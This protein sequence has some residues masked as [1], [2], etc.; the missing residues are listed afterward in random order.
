MI[1]E[2]FISLMMILLRITMK[3]A[4]IWKMNTEEWKKIDERRENRYY[5]TN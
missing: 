5:I 1:A 2:D 3:L 4:L